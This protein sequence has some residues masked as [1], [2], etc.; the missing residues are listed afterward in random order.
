M[1]KY[2]YIL[3]SLS[4]LTSCTNK[5][6]YNSQQIQVEYIEK[7]CPNCNGIGSVKTSTGTKIVLGILTLGPGALCETETCEM[8]KGTGVVKVRKLNN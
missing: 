4:L 3:L 6:K 7:Y 2:I 1:K 8:C 5:A